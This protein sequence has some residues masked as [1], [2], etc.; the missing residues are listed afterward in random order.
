[1]S[2]QFYAAHTVQQAGGLHST[3]MRS[4]WK[5]N[6]G[7]DETLQLSHSRDAREDGAVKLTH[8]LAEHFTGLSFNAVGDNI[9]IYNNNDDT[10]WE[11]YLNGYLSP[12]L[13][14]IRMHKCGFVKRPKGHFT[15]SEIKSDN[16]KLSNYMKSIYF[17]YMHAD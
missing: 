4:C 15:A 8:K 14:A 5:K 13:I 6:R 1:M 2:F 11:N 17:K 7:H 9:V 16:K 10:L 3:E 12:V